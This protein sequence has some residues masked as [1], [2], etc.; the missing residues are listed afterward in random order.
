MNRSGVSQ[1][2]RE[3]IA[4]LSPV[5]WIHTLSRLIGICFFAMVGARVDRKELS[6][7][8]LREL[9]QNRCERGGGRLPGA[10]HR[11]PQPAASF[12]SRA[13]GLDLAGNERSARWAMTHPTD[14]QTRLCS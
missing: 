1:T 5:S 7:P 9:R 11:A 13:M 8:K 2:K 14:Q 6:S 10:A 4:D 12:P 3:R